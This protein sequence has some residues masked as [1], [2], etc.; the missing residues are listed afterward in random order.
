[1]G[2]LHRPA[3]LQPGRPSQPLGTGAG[4]PKE[5]LTGQRKSKTLRNACV[6]EGRGPPALLILRW[7]SQHLAKFGSGTQKP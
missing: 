3:G 5:K 6:T 1:M 2:P 7:E 4:P